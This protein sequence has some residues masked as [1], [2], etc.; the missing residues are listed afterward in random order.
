MPFF[1]LKAFLNCSMTMKVTMQCGPSLAAARTLVTPWQTYAQE[2][3]SK[4]TEIWPEA[5]PQ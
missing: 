2:P 3:N 5:L 4:L 1:A